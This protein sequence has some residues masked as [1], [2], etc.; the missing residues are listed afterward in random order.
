MVRIMCDEKDRKIKTKGEEKIR[1]QRVYRA[2]DEQKMGG[3]VETVSCR[4]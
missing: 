4:L 2:A 3:T 1:R